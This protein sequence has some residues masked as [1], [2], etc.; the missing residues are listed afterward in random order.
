MDILS[1]RCQKGSM[2]SATN[3]RSNRRE[4]PLAQV[5]RKLLDPVFRRQGFA[6][7]EI[8][9]KWPLI[10]GESLSAHVQPERISFPRHS[11]TGGTL[12]V[13]VEGAFALELQHR[14]H[15]VLDRLN[16]YFGYAAIEKIV[17]RQ[18]PLPRRHEQQRAPMRPLTP[19]E[20]QTIDKTV[21]PIKDDRL[22]QSLGRVGRNLAAK[23]DKKSR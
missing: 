18:G 15:E 7:N 21:A 9:T 12:F 19:E 11:R 13:R 22:K 8:I 17:I 14:T 16:T 2:N 1:V 5:A 10:V 4:R 3:K 6:R 20:E 23:S